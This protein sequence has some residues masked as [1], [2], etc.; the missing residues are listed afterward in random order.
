MLLLWS[1]SSSRLVRFS[2][3]GVHVESLSWVKS[4]RVVMAHASSVAKSAK[5]QCQAAQSQS[6]LIGIS[7]QVLK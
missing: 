1:L 5:F 6:E 2:M 7:L 3:S 4:A